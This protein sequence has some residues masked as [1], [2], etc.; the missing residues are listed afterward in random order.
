MMTYEAAEIYRKFGLDT[1]MLDGDVART[2]LRLEAER[3]ALRARLDALTAA[4]AP[5][6]E[7]LEKTPERPTP[8]TV[9]VDEDDDIDPIAYIYD[10]RDATAAIVHD[11]PDVGRLIVAA[12]NAVRAVR[13][14]LEGK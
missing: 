13:A 3:D 12:V 7:A 4:L 6:L 2:L 1:F 14:V 11:Y 9:D 8:W 5:A 10:A